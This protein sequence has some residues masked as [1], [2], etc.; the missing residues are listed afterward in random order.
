[1][2]AEWKKSG[3]AGRELQMLCLG[4]ILPDTHVYESMPLN[5]LSGCISCQ[6]GDKLTDITSGIQA[7]GTS[8]AFIILR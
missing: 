4:T 6:Q 8:Q 7:T 3:K 2:N 1:M 5:I